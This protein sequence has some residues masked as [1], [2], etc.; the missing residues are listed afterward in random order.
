MDTE[1][2]NA[3]ARDLM[4]PVLGTDQ[5]EALIARV[6]AAETLADVRELRGFLARA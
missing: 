6:N 3:K 1:A 4:A 2:V 5:T